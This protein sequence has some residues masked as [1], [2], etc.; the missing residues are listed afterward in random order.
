MVHS[1]LESSCS[2]LADWNQKYINETT[3][4][5]VWQ[6][7]KCVI[8]LIGSDN[9]YPLDYVALIQLILFN[10]GIN[11]EYIH[12]ETNLISKKPTF[13]QTVFPFPSK[14]FIKAIYS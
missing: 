14:F 12:W 6:G 7:I 3:E 10:T 9:W 1:R 8:C 13:I 5:D 11:Y 2:W 4:R